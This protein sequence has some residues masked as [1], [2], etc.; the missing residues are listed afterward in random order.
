MAD[1]ALR[2]DLSHVLERITDGFFA[3]DAQWQIIYINAQARKL[4]HAPPDCIGLHWLVVFPKARGRLF[5][6]EYQRAM[7]DQRPVQ[8]VEYSATAERWL[9][10]RAYPA[11]DGLSVYFR[12]VT[13]RVE[14]QRE[15]ERASARQ[16]AMIDFGRAA[17]A[18]T[19][20]DELLDRGIELVREHLDVPVVEIYR[21]DRSNDV[22]G[23]VRCAGWQEGAVLDVAEPPL[24]HLAAVL[25]TGEPF[26][27]SDVRI[28]PRV[29][30]LARLD[31]I[32]VL[33]CIANLVGTV[34]A[35]IGAVVV[36]DAKPRT[37][38][39]G[40]VR[41]VQSL[42][43]SIAEIS[44][45]LESN[46]LM[47]QVLE[48]MHDAFVAIDGEM[49]LTYVN[50][51]MA[52]IAHQSPAEMLG[53]PLLDYVRRIGGPGISD[54]IMSSY[55]TALREQ[56]SI[57]FE[58]E[59]RGR[60][61]E[62]RLYPFGSGVAGY[63]RD[64]TARKAEEQRV[65]DLAAELEKRVAERTVQ[66]E[67]AN[68]ELESFSY[69]VSHD[70][71]APLR[72]IDGFSQALL[73]DYGATLD[74]RAQSYLDRVRR[75]AQRMSQLIDALLKLA[76]VART[77]IA[78]Y[79]VDVSASAAAVVAELREIHPERAVEIEIEPGLT[80][81]AE[82]H[83]V[84]IV[85]QNLLGNAWKFTRNTPNAQVRVGKNSNGEYYV[86]D[87]GAGF[88]PSYAGKLFSAFARLHAAEEYEGT[89]IGLAT[90]ARIVHRHGGGIRAEGAVGAGASF[91]FTLPEEG[92]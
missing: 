73:E 52:R 16:Q 26:V 62:S 65:L 28:D 90:V 88:D 66:L 78:R 1:A 45:S 87:N 10:V 12:D 47:S 63:V 8:F 74:P 30:A 82:P 21:Y 32:G 72:A 92:S 14:A 33:S 54:L 51:R 70:L 38:T 23:A 37:F 86:R 11:A 85:L 39:L 76:K 53:R 34:H 84:Q 41:F 42:S 81:R 59:D 17:L 31:R 9:E 25:R 2:P 19:S 44:T 24:D 57:T 15:V 35:P 68:K 27:C 20:Y 18:G 5:E 67:Q 29:P 79:A 60:W 36:Y 50:A 64:I 13:S 4:L 22:F 75:A 91:Y 43:Q 55:A 61:Y 7:Q 77:P 80:A 6:R 46:V 49:R 40:E 56:R 89:G 58:N 48:S 69:S 3:L 83:L 71:R